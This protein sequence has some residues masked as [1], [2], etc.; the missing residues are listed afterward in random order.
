MNDV[1]AEIDR[2]VAEGYPDYNLYAQTA[3]SVIKFK[4]KTLIEWTDEL[5]TPTLAAGASISQLEAYN[6]VIL[7]LNETVIKNLAYA[8]ATLATSKMLY[9]RR[10]DE[11]KANLFEQSVKRLS[12]EAAESI[13]KRDLADILHAYELASMFCEYWEV[14]F[15]KIQLVNDRLTSLN[16][17]KNHEVK[18]GGHV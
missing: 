15:E 13:A 14:Q 10:L 7:R 16:I 5:E 1:V 12:Q 6:F 11:V 17:L 9:K 8:R 18:V 4:D 3:N 2:V